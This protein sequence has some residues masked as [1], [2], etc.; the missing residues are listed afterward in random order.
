MELGGTTCDKKVTFEYTNL[1]YRTLLPGAAG[2]L[3]CV[4]G[5]SDQNMAK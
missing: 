5:Y 3:R 4:A 2:T 1:A